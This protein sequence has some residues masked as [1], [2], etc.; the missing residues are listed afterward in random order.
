MEKQEKT[1]RTK[2]ITWMPGALA[3]ML[4]SVLNNNAFS[5]GFSTQ[6][7]GFR[8]VLKDCLGDGGADLYRGQE[9]IITAKKRLTKHAPS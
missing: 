3:F 1:A 4:N 5:G 9:D 7:E 2:Q 6:E 8:A